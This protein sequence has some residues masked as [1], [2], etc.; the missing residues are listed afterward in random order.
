MQITDLLPGLMPTALFAA[1]LWLGRNLIITRLKSAVQHEFDQKI[2]AVRSEQRISEE[3]FKAVIRQREADIASLKS[4][5][6]SGIASTQLELYK[7]RVSATEQ[8]W[9]AVSTLSGAKGAVQYIAIMK[10]DA[11]AEQVGHDNRLRS[12]VEIM[13]KMVGDV[14][15]YA[16]PDAAKAEPFVSEVVWSLYQAYQ[17][18]LT[19]SLSQLHML[20]KGVDPRELLNHAGVAQL[21]KLALPSRAD[22]IDQH[23]AAGYPALVD[24]LQ[25]ALLVELRK[26]LTGVDA[27][28]SSVE[29]AHAI[30]AQVTKI[31]DESA[32]A[33]VNIKLKAAEE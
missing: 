8:I 5:A 17:A 10:M 12:A 2:E 22:H 27:D 20:A 19:I 33:T 6:I 32:Q 28:A 31:K 14:E 30:Q 7:R 11:L 4:S 1:A 15:K 29:R 21:A 26:M 13:A 24:E 25:K 3:S 18:I 23:G 16:V 9:S